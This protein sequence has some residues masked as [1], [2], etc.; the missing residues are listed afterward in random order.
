MGFKI[1]VNLNLP[2]SD[3]SF[4]CDELDAGKTSAVLT[5]TLPKNTYETPSRD[6]RPSVT[7]LLMCVAGRRQS[8]TSTRQAATPMYHRSTFKGTSIF[9]EKLQRVIRGFGAEHFMSFIVG[10][11]LS[12]A[13]SPSCQESTDDHSEKVANCVSGGMSSF[14]VKQGILFTLQIADFLF[15]RKCGNYKAD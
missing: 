3:R 12:F 11:R 2:E 6:V 8:V 1:H 5:L 13:L 14:L 9:N 7:L 4:V 10:V 15:R